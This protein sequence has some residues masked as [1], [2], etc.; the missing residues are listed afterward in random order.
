MSNQT[1]KTTVSITELVRV[2][3]HKKVP[4]KIDTGA[5]RS[6]I[7]ASDVEVTPEGILKF[8]LFGPTSSH[9]TGEILET[10]DFNVV[11]IRSSNGTTQ[12]RY[13]VNL[14]L[15]LS[16]HNIKASF[17]LSNRSAQHY[18]ILIGRRTLR[19]KFI[20]DVGHKS[21][22]QPD[23]INIELNKKLR[24]DPYKFH[25]DIMSTPGKPAT[26]TPNPSNKEST[27]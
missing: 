8:K 15:R 21:I 17:N 6:A 10:T 12:L 25:R 13:R 22:K 18:P 26:N 1:E 7:W 16:G 20:V 5:D 4:A 9:Y 2:G 14:P 27:K 19:G 3:N 11:Q 23:P 24:A